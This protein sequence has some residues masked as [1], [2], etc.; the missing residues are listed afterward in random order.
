MESTAP[1]FLALAFLVLLFFLLRQV[2][3]WYWGVTEI[4]GLLREIRDLL[5]GQQHGE[6]PLVP[7]DR[8]RV[9][10]SEVQ[11]SDQPSTSAIDESEF[12]RIVEQQ[13]HDWDKRGSLGEWLK[14]RRIPKSRLDRLATALGV[15]DQD[16]ASMSYDELL[17]AAAERSPR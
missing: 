13:L 17:N 9:P 12:N 4:I 11:H 7:P 3:L 15:S 16:V 8:R 5:K 6:A 14:V 2:N 10:A 1:Y